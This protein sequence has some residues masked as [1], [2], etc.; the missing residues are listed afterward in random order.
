[1]PIGASGMTTACLNTS[2]PS[3]TRSKII[4]LASKSLLPNSTED[5]W[6]ASRPQPVQSRTV[7]NAICSISQKFVRL[8]SPDL[9]LSF[10]DSVDFQLSLQLKA[11]EKAN[12]PSCR[13]KP[14]PI[15]LVLHAIE[16]AFALFPTRERQVVANMIYLAFFFPPVLVN[17]HVPPLTVKPS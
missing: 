6:I 17:T 2:A 14:V 11:F 13:V 5:G 8:G 9:R 12:A 10:A 3:S 1:M 16:F 4:S 15:T 7:S